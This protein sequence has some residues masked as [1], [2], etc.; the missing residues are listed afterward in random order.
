MTA[1]S[2]RAQ[3][4]AWAALTVAITA[5]YPSITRLGVTRQAIEPLGLATIR[6]AVAGLVLL[7]CFLLHARHLDRRGWA[8]ALILA[9]C[10][11]IP[12]AA[13]IAG[14]LA[15]APAAHG[16][17]LTL[18]LMPAIT[19]LIGLAGGREPSR[20]AAAGAAV[21]AAGAAWLALQDVGA[22]GGALLGH[23]MFALAAVMGAIYFHRLRASGLTALQGA[24]VVAVLS[25]VAGVAA[26][27][28]TGGLGRIAALPAGTLAVQAVFQGVL[29]GVVAMAA[30]NRAIALLGPAPATTCLSLVPAAAMLV[31][32]PLLGETPSVPEALAIGLMVAGAVLSAAPSGLA[33][34]WP[35]APPIGTER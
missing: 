31:A 35:T 30:T 21:I 25:G 28:L 14:G 20:Q 4:L 22:G 34:G 23:A 33:V 9:A 18:G 1:L 17:A 12:L 7:P 3:G 13:L 15:L 8:E 6:Y 19:L 26:L 16:S 27:A 32:V 10:Q 29:V 11:G 2:P 24:A 5:A